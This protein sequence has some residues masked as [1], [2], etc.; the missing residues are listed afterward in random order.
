MPIFR[1][2][3]FVNGD[4][5]SIDAYNMGVLALQRGDYYD[6][7]KHLRDAA[8]RGYVSALYNL[9]LLHGSGMISPYSIDF[10]TDCFYKAA[11]G[12][13]PQASSSVAFLEAA[14]RGGFGFDNL[15]RFAGEWASGGGLN[16]LLMMCACRF[17]DALCRKYGATAD[18]IAYELDAASLSDDRAVLGF[19]E[20]SGL[21]QSFYSG[22]LNRLTK[23][24][25]ADQIT[26]GLNGMH[27]GLKQLGTR[28]PYCRFARCT[29][30]GYI[31][32]K[33]AFGGKAAP[34]RGLD[35][36]FEA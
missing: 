5:A 1:K 16:H 22:G 25:A 8:V 32:E 12:G 36:F 17:A 20:R 34:L 4:D 29:V 3:I 6:A 27:L 15:A 24:S 13:H 2:P 31:I 14:D 23:G 35:R 30:V 7:D 26:D 9:S 33:S 10:A 11:A 19:V 21:S 28:D 18:V